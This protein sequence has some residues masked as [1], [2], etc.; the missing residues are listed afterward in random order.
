MMS[1]PVSLARATL[2]ARGAQIV[3]AL[4]GRWF[5]EQGMCRCPA[6][7]DRT[8]SLSVRVGSRSLLFKCFAGCD[9]MV[10]LLA[11]ARLD[12]AALRAVSG[13]SLAPAANPWLVD[14]IVSLWDHAQSIEGTPAEEYLAARGLDGIGSSALRFHPHTPLRR[15]DGLWFRPAM[16]GLVT[17]GHEIV[18][19][20]RTFLDLTR[21][22]SQG[23]FRPLRRLLGRPGRAAV[24]LAAPIDVLGLAE[25][26]ET[27]LAAMA[28]LDIPVWATLG[29][30]RFANIAIPSHV[31]TLLLLPDRD[32]AGRRAEAQARAIYALDGKRIETCFPPCG[33]NDW[34]DLPAGRRTYPPTHDP[35]GS[36]RGR[37]GGGSRC[38]EV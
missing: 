32:A 37:E 31:R 12:P 21:A 23:P 4:E 6:H 34:N 8:P 35:V 3:R 11:I 16:L 2:V 20:Q 30:E 13:A 7:L 22:G 19:L 26:I 17:Q 36:G 18:A 10:V 38:R 5:G 1:G 9:A 25:G 14:R 15:H 28:C 24:K 27:G 29:A 33:A